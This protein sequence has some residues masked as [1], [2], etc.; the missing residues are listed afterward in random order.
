MAEKVDLGDL[1]TH[2]GLTWPYDEKN[3]PG[4]DAL[5]ERGRRAFMAKHSLLHMNKSLGK[6]AKEV[7]SADHGQKLDEQMLRIATAK[8]LVNV[9]KLAYELHMKPEA[10]E[11]LAETILR[12]DS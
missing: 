7:E 12:G 1:M 8:M 9:L 10:I 11:D 4:F 2:I 6:I 3:Y 5:D